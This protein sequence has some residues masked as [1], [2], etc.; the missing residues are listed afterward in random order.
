MTGNTEAVLGEDISVE[1]I[2]YIAEATI[3]KT[4]LKK[5]MS[6]DNNEKFTE[7]SA[8]FDTYMQL[9]EGNAEIVIN[10][11]PHLLAR[12]QSVVIPAPERSF[13]KANGQFKIISTI[14]KSSY[15]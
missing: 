15:E 9:I 2:E 5:S 3:V 7:T 10:G 6:F 1:I 14:V 12:G 13:I 4:I 8:P 11:M